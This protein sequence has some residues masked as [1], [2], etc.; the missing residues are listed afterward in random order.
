M[1]KQ[2]RTEKEFSNLD[3][4]VAAV[5]ETR[6]IDFLVTIAGQQDICVSSA[7]AM[8]EFKHTLQQRNFGTHEG[9]T[10]TVWLL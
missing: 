1:S 9:D 4:A 8:T 5:G 10:V 2:S 7:Y 6:H 3:A